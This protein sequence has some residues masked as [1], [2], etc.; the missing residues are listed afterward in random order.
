MVKRRYLKWNLKRA[1]SGLQV[2]RSLFWSIKSEKSL[3]LFRLNS[4]EKVQTCIKRSEMSSSHGPNLKPIRALTYL[5]IHDLNH[6]Y[7]NISKLCDGWDASIIIPEWK[8]Y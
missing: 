5:I 7:Y 2:C 8:G 4:N 1:V 6:Y 3:S